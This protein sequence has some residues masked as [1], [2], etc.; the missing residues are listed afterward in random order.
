MWSSYKEFM[1]FALN[2]MELS[3]GLSIPIEPYLNE[4]TFSLIKT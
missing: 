3:T 4:D 1:K 2:G